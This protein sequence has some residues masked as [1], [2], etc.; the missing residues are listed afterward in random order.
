MDLAKILI[1]NLRSDNKSLLLREALIL[2]KEGDLEHCKSLLTEAGKNGESN[3]YIVLGKISND[4]NYF[5][6]AIKLG[7]PVGLY[8]LGEH[9]LETGN[10]PLARDYLERAY[11][12]GIFQSSLMLH[13]IETRKDW[14]YLWYV[15]FG[16]LLL[17]KRKEYL[18]SFWQIMLLTVLSLISI[19]SITIT[20]FFT[21]YFFINLIFSN[22]FYKSLS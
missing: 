11:E 22:S 18:A 1:R 15:A 19:K 20:S 7:N 5:K 3:A 14:D 13:E 16:P 9:Y 21:T 8:Y 10:Y 2:I 12:H 17:L 6:E 4:E